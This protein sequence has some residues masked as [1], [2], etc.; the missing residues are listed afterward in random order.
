MKTKLAEAMTAGVFVEFRDLEGNTLGQAV[1]ADWHGRPLPGVGDM[2]TSDACA[3]QACGAGMSAATGTVKLLG[4]V[5]SRH[6]DLQRDA[7]DGAPCV[8]VRLIVEACDVSIR[9]P[10]ARQSTGFSRN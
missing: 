5:T 9:R 2:L 1:Y 8:W 4:R 7:D 3:S 10:A 6:F